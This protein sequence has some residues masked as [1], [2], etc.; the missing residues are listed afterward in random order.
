MVAAQGS[1]SVTWLPSLATLQPRAA[2]P[3]PIDDLWFRLRE[4]R[5]GKD[6]AAS[7]PT[8]PRKCPRCVHLPLLKRL[9]ISSSISGCQN[10]RQ[11]R[12]LFVE[13]FPAIV[14]MTGLPT[15]AAFVHDLDGCLRP[16]MIGGMPW[17]LPR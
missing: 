15:L 11:R 5:H 16:A 9:Y 14:S 7:A 1:T 2:G 10:K 4:N 6:A 13:S 12:Q 8:P 17:H 3:P